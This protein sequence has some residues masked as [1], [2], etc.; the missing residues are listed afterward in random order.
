LALILAVG[1]L[2]LLACGPPK[3]VPVTI[4]VDGGQ[5]VVQT[6]G[7]TVRDVLQEN[8]VTLGELDRVEPD[9]WVETTP[10]MTVTV[11]RVEEKLEFL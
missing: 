6:S 9:L 11:V 5:R 10:D 7:A 2:T 3:P 8:G 1:L 4:V